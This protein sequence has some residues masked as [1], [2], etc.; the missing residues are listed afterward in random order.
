MRMTRR[1]FLGA[2]AGLTA[3][4]GLSPLLPNLRA[5]QAAGW[6]TSAPPV[7]GLGFVTTLAADPFNPATLLAG[8]DVH[9]LKRT[10]NA[11]QFWGQIDTGTWKAGR[12][13]ISAIVPH[14]KTRGKFYVL[15]GSDL[16][17][18][19]V[20]MTADW[21][22]H[23]QLLAI[24]IVTEPQ[25]GAINGLP[26][27]RVYGRLLALDASGSRDVLYAASYS[28]GLYRSRD[29]GVTWTNIAFS[30][31]NMNLTAVLL[32][33]T[34][35]K[36]IYVGWRNNTQTWT[37]THGG[38]KVSTDGGHTWTDHVT[39]VAVRDLVIDP[40]RP[41]DLYAAALTG[42]VW[43]SLAG[44]KW[45]ASSSGLPLKTPKGD[46]TFFNAI[47]VDPTR[48]GHVLVGTGEGNTNSAFGSVY[49]STDRG[50][51]WTNLVTANSKNVHV[52]STVIVPSFYYLGGEGDAV[53][54]VR[55][56]P[57]PPTQPNQSTPTI[58]VAGRSLTWFSADG[59]ANWFPSSAG[60]EGAGRHFDVAIDPVTGSLYMGTGDWALIRSD[61]ARHTFKLVSLTFP[62]GEVRSLCFAF[63]TK[64]LLLG[65]G[66]SKDVT[67]NN[68]GGVFEGSP[69]NGTAGDGTTW[70]QVGT[71][72]LPS[73]RV[74]GLATAPSNPDVVYAALAQNGVYQ[75]KDGGTTFALMST[76]GLPTPGTLF[77][78]SFTKIPIAV[79]PTEPNAVYVL[80]HVHGL[81]AYSPATTTWTNLSGG[82]PIT[83]TPVDQHAPYQGFALDPT[84]PS[85][86]YLATSAG[87]FRSVDAGSSWMQVVIPNTE[88][89][90]PVVVDQA[91]VVFASTALPDEASA[92][93]DRP[94][95][96]VSTNGGKD[97]VGAYVDGQFAVNLDALA[98]DP[99]AAST[100]WAASAGS[101]FSLAL[102][103]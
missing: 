84:Q 34:N 67:A 8:G 96:Y 56:V 19:G 76:H 54:A 57:P 100:V 101:L 46:P 25:T 91:G 90:G 97:W 64:R 79:H 27:L 14:P 68:W 44:G 18:G 58:W 51:L 52:D 80:D 9:G 40:S 61:T 17:H 66:S 35:P 55:V 92:L 75:S 39:G 13:G 30:T 65:A 29:G 31:A 63:T 99:R 71:T 37:D 98:V 62:Q 86:L 33:P 88:S 28:D 85:R 21:G 73:A 36:T 15:S 50:G 93:T 7:P 47:E 12:Y 20:Y 94:G 53:S 83:G 24:G 42:G 78:G 5:V 95:I 11:G 32:D 38:V 10:T 26:V 103:S 3:G 74:V 81:F 45:T 49:H 89:F 2:S 87:L 43:R 22:S 6:V 1:R 4:L 59:G 102:S 16:S 77:P 41:T 48:A 72:T 82:V 69:R 70:N 60:L 23:W